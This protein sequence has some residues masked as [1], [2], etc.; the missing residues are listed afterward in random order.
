MRLKSRGC[1]AYLIE[2]RSRKILIDTGTDG[3]LLAKQI[4]EL[5]AII[6]THAHFDHIAGARELE[7]IFGCPIYVHP[8]DMPYVLGEKEFNFSGFMGMMAK[9]LEK[10]S[11]Y[12]APENVR[13]IF[14]LESS[15]KTVHL[16]GH[17][18]GSVCIFKGSNAYCGDL[19][20][21]GGKLSLRSFCSDY[22]RY[23]ES[24]KEFIEMEWEI[25]YPG[26]GN[27]VRRSYLKPLKPFPMK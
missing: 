2:D 12:R 24:V 20:R 22:K 7:R 18:T 21:N 15:L 25:A 5:D 3:K 6:I 8:E 23:L 19:I 26:H 27:E 17:T 11:N 13:S 1:N 10:L 16:P 14:E 4:E 9:M